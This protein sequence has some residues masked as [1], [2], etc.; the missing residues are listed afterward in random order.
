VRIAV[1]LSDVSDGLELWSCTYDREVQDV[2][3]IQEEIAGSIADS[4]RIELSRSERTAPCSG[5]HPPELAAGT[6]NPRAYRMY[7]RGMEHSRKADSGDSHRSI[8]HFERAIDED[9]SF[10]AAYAGLAHSYASLGWFN[11]MRPTEAWTR[12]EASAVTALKLDP[13]QGTVRTVLGCARALLNWDWTGAEPE[14]HGACESDT[15]DPLPRVWYAVAC[16]A[17]LRRTEEALREM[18]IALQLESLSP[19]IHAQAGLIH[20][21]SGDYDKAAEHCSSALD[22]DP[23]Y[24]PARWYLGRIFLQTLNL[25]AAE[26]ELLQAQQASGNLPSIA[27][28]LAQ[29]HVQ[30]GNRDK[31]Q[32]ISARLRRLARSR[33]VSPLHLARVHIAL[34]EYDAVFELLEAARNYRCCRMTELAVDPVYT[35][36]RTDPRFTRFVRA[37][38]LVGEPLSIRHTA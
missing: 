13:T 18:E 20:F 3:A 32:S 15:T 8:F 10:G 33:Y 26:G 24:W 6:T 2:F 23:G 19:Q 4:L 16:L 25:T 11:E 36:L 27:G 22:L 7:I 17:P 35:P 34:R 9:P 12:A 30:Q 29:C 37:V 38:G 21:Y 31:A 14:F 1:Q 28:C 5:S